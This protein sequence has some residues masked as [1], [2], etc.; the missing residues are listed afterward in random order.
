MVGLG[1]GLSVENL[2]AKL[3][4]EALIVTGGVI[5]LLIRTISAL[6]LYRTVRVT[7]AGAR[8]S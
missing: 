7:R 8:V 5:E 2:P 1:T 4:K 6:N 3:I